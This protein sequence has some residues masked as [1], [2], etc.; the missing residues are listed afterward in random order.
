[1]V[2]LICG[3]IGN[4]ALSIYFGDISAVRKKL[5]NMRSCTLDLDAENTK[6]A[7]LA[8]QNG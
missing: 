6:C 2:K 3:W 4:S 5:L 8:Q 1:L 7:G